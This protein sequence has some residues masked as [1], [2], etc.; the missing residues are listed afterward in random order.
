MSLQGTVGAVSFSSPLL[1]Q[2]PPKKAPKFT[3][4]GDY[5]DQT[6]FEGRLR[7]I[8][9]KIDPRTLLLGEEELT[10]SQ[11]LLDKFEKAGCL[12]VGVTDED[13]WEAKR[14]VEACIH[15][16]TKERMFVLG[17]MSA[18]LS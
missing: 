11:E 14:K 3:T 8:L 2:E 18:Y 1:A 12:P 16:V 6:Q 10:K 5:Y 7:G 13:M 15:P 9:E 4:D 17:R